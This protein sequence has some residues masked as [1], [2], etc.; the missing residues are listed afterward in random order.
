[1][2][3]ASKYTVG[4]ICALPTEFDAAQAFLDEEHDDQPAVAQNDNNNYALGRIGN[5]NV[6]IAVLPDGEYGT[7]AA[8][9]VARD[10]LHSFPNVRIGLMVGIGGGAPTKHDI[11]LGDVVVSSR[12]GGKGGVFQYDFGKAI[13]NQDI[14]FEHTD[15]LDQPPTVLRTAVSALKSRYKRKG[16]QLNT[17]IDKALD[18]WPRLREEYS[19]P[20]L[21]SDRL[22]RSE[23]IHPNSPEGCDA[24]CGDDPTYL[25]GRNK[26]GEHSDDP[27][28]HY[29]LIASANQ[30]MKD[31]SIR[32]KLATEK[33]VLCFEMEAA[34]LMNHFP[35][36]VIRGI[37]DYSDSHKN[38]QWQGFAAMTAAAYAT[39]LLRQIPPNKVEAERRIADV[40]S[41]LQ[42]DVDRM[43]RD[44]SETKAVATTTRNNQHLDKVRRWL[45]PSDP[46]S[47]ASMARERRHAGTGTWLLESTTF[48][49]W[50]AGKR[51][52]LWL[53]G[54]AG[55]GKTVLSTTIL[56]HLQQTAST[57]TIMFFF[58][59]NDARKQTLDNLVRS[60]A[61]QLYHTGDEALRILDSLY[62]SHDDG[63]RQPDASTLS[64][65]I[66]LMMQK[67]Q[68]VTI[69]LDA[70]DECTTRSDLLLWI[71]RL[72][73][74]SA[75]NNVQIIVTG[76]PE[77][78]FQR[79]IPQLFKDDNCM[80]LDKKAVDADIRSYVAHELEQRRGFTE[81]KLPQ[82]LFEQIR[83]KV[84]DGAD[85]M[86]RWAAC[87]LDS[88]LKCLHV[89]AIEE[90]LE[91]LPRDLNE[92]YQRMLENIPEELK[93]DALRLLQ[94]LIYSKRP[95]TL[96]EAIDITATQIESIG[97]RSF[98][99][100]RRLLRADDILQYCPSLT[101]IAEFSRDGKVTKAIQLAHFS[102]KEYL[103]GKDQFQLPTASIT[104]TWTCLTYLK[105]I[106]ITGTV[107]R[108]KAEF[109]LARHAAE[110]WME[111]AKEGEISESIVQESTNFL[112]DTKTFQC[113][114]RL[115]QPDREWYEDPGR[116]SGSRLYYSCH[117]GLHKVTRSLLEQAA[118]VNVQGGTFGN[119]LQAASARGHQEII[120]LL[121]E[122]GADV[123][124]QGGLYGNALQAA[125]AGGHPEIIQLLLEKGADVNAQ[126]GRYGNALQAASS[127]GHQEIIQL[128]LEKKADINAQGGLYDNALQ[129]ASAGGHPEIIQLLLEKGADVNAR[130]SYYG[131]AL[132]AASYGGHQE[133]VQLLLEKRADVN[134]QGG[135]YGNALQA[136]SYGGHQ[137]IIQ[138]LLEKGADVNAQGGYFG[139]ALQ[140]ASIRGHQEIIQL[141][142]EKGADVNAQGGYYGNALYAASSKGHQE[143]VQLL[144]EKG[145]DVNAQGGEYGSALQA[146]SYGGHQEIVQLL[147]EKGADINAQG[148]EYGS[149]L[150]A[151][152]Y[153]GHQEIVQLLLEKGADVNAQGGRYGNA[154]QAASY[155]GHQ[156][157]VQLLLEKGAD[158]NA[159]GG[160]YGNDLQA[161]SYGGHQEIVQLLLEKGADVNAQGGRYGNALQAASSEGHQEIVQLLLE[162]GADVNAQG[163]EYG[164]ALQAASYGGHQEIVQLLLEKGADINAQG[165]EYGSALQAASYGGHQEIIQ[166]LLEKRADINAQGGLYGNALQAAS[167]GGHQEIVQLLLEKGADVNA[168]GGRYGNDLQAA[169]Y[170]GHQEIIQ[171]LLEKGADVNTQGGEYGNALQAASYGGHQ[172]IVQ[173]LLEKRADVNAQG[174][175]Y[176]NALQAASYGGHQEIIQLL[177]EKRA[178]INAQGGEYGS[179][180]QAASYGG[181][182]EIVQLLLEKGA[183]VNTQ[184]GLYG[185]ALQAA[186]IRGHQEIIQLLLEKGADVNAQG[187]YYGNALY[188]ASSKGHQEIVQL[189]LEKGADVNAQ[190][191]YYGNALQAASYGGHQEIVQ[192]LL[193]KG[194]DVNA[195]GGRYGNALQAASS[196]GHQEIVRL[197]LEIGA[198]V[199]KQGGEYGNA[200][201]AASYGG[202]KGVV[203]LLLNLSEVDSEAKN[204]RSGRTALSYAAENGYEAIVEQLIT[205]AGADPTS[206]DNIRRTPLFFAC[207]EGHN[208]VVNILLLHNAAAS[209]LKDHYGST[210]LSAAARK[211]HS[212][213]LR[214]LV[215]TGS[216]DINSTDN[217]GRTP[218]WWARRYGH[219]E[220]FQLLVEVGDQ[221]VFSDG[222]QTAVEV[223]TKRHEKFAHYCD[224]CTFS[225]SEDSKYYHCSV[226]NGDD[227]DICLDCFH[228]GGRCLEVSHK[229]TLRES[230]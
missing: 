185:N 102:V 112:Q 92:T 56:D 134:T 22:Y 217:F 115:Y 31:A 215:S 110:L 131:N 121:L 157:I 18:R 123:N 53:Y 105:D 4:W 132:Q 178:D 41:L 14:P 80:L 103:V 113:W 98:N 128:L 165:G 172:D 200:L 214:S 145:A 211:G 1:M 44:V 15:F 91:R 221:G 147:L 170:G 124:A 176:G 126:G 111:H 109:P 195:Q 171:L 40:L 76:R 180:L 26:R 60:L 193:E 108:I 94:F 182:Q 141:L 69:V 24:I 151:A 169:S 199:N 129:A 97:Q 184:G 45:S 28:I 204:P 222:S 64:A 25:V 161:A 213:V 179:A 198:D 63:R 95:L 32:D 224:I 201:Q 47:N 205:V 191:G 226:C 38:K 137:E 163:G 196:E 153:G 174:G 65:C 51:R 29:G 88:L 155:G 8:A 106:K 86:F 164:S 7:S 101:S 90:A 162:K 12:D 74:G 50:E 39:D 67:L 218:L 120:Q 230:Q 93:S 183:D 6:V 175:E 2:S 228:L 62:H 3:D 140:A 152:S 13:Q 78:E 159:Q 216:I 192:L 139:N 23:I 220:V 190:G 210:P 89:Q 36:L 9:A 150:Q 116:P 72:T 35:C 34:G 71:R 58:D 227:L 43:Q 122:K 16:H 125:S 27:A 158:V 229:L 37:C 66:E 197:L 212:D 146:A 166:L 181:H 96:K 54:L 130:G 119:A 135:R 11:R 42:E 49:E 202:H 30:L 223:I 127:E 20:P 188:A 167:Y 138:L 149:A 114:G 77:A 209:D 87:Q 144:L 156:E 208:A 206:V 10:M 100:K 19:R 79:E 160:R 203:S 117:E 154:L 83:I 5:H 207:N 59:F 148:G 133:I 104:I 99:V 118:D 68:K 107:E 225:I 189:L 219:A 46:S 186:S 84:G 173:L 194:A 168:Q 187:G 177:L 82:D 57:P 143:I 81:K 33:G 142:L 85:G 73:L 61:F 136:A 55:C 75:T 21:E 48:N 70:L 52:H 17:A